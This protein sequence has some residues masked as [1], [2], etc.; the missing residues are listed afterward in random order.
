MNNV[1]FQLTHI[2]DVHNIAGPLVPYNHAFPKRG[3]IPRDR[4]SY[5]IRPL[6]YL[7]ATTAGYKTVSYLQKIERE[8]KKKW[9][10]E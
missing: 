7:L 2:Q 5:V 10:N 4:E 9:K 8:V 3:L 6:L 1:V